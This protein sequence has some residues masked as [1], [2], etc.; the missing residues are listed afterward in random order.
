MEIF[1]IKLIEDGKMPTK[2]NPSDAGFDCYVRDYEVIYTDGKKPKILYVKYKLGFALEAPE[3]WAT[4]LYQRSSVFKYDLILANAVGV[5][6]SGYRGEI[7]AIF[8]PT[9]KMPKIYE[10]GEKICQI[11]PYQLPNV[12]LNQVEELD[13]NTDRGGG[14]GSTGK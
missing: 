4:L 10:V 1:K 8:K 7:Q 2:A 12:T 9:K 13:T 3:G 11:I 14:F 6:D 5:I